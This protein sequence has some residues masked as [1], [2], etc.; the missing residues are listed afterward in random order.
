MK[1]GGLF[2]TYQISIMKIVF[3]FLFAASLAA[4]PCDPVDFYRGDDGESIYCDI[5]SVKVV[6]YPG[7]KFVFFGNEFLDSYDL[8]DFA[9]NM[10][11][12][13]S[14]CVGVTPNWRIFIEIYYGD[15]DCLLRRAVA[16]LKDS[17]NIKR[18]GFG[19]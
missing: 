12:Y 10:N 5:D 16:Y 17:A 9:H 6:R 8:V 3:F 14:V 19:N 4:Q 13:G 1:G 15:R 18:K 2:F 7:G 11:R